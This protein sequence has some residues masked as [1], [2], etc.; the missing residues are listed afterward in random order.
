M[1]A[2]IRLRLI[3][4]ARQNVTWS[5]SMLNEQMQLGLDFNLE[6]DR[7]L[8][9]D[10]L[11]EISIHEH[12]KDRPLLS[13][14]IIH[15]NDRDQGDGFYKMCSRLNGKDWQALKRDT[16]WEEKVINDCF[17]FWEK[18]NNYKNFRDDF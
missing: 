13:A 15:K 12:S 11:E 3:E 14:L 1:E 8:I 17:E 10:L 6:R 2:R 7:S 5:Y 18:P 4:L 9:G 16:A